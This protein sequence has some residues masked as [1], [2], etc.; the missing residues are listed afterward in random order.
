M[1]YNITEYLIMFATLAVLLLIF[2]GII[3][4]VIE[5]QEQLRGDANISEE[6]IE[7]PFSQTQEAADKSQPPPF[8][9][10]N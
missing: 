8:P 5:L 7:K 4:A 6:R 3:I 2:F 10:I 9:Q 1:R